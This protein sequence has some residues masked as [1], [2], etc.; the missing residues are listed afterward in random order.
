V[1]ISSPK[2]D[3]HKIDMSNDVAARHWAKRLGKSKEEI[4]AA[5]EKVGNNCA[6]VRKELG[7]EPEARN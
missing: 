6:T 2:P 1:E 7:C 3:R 5:I 4:V